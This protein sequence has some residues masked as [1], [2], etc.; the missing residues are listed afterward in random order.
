VANTGVASIAF[1]DKLEIFRHAALLT[2]AT[3]VQELQS[4]LKQRHL[5][6]GKVDG[7]YGAELRTAIET[8]EK[9]EGLQVTGLATLTTLKR[10]GGGVPVVRKPVRDRKPVRRAKS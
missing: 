3:Q 2:S 4:I 10:L 9:A 8:Y 7:R 6:A 5:F 1:A